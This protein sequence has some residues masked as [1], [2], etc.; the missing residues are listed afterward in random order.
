[1]AIGEKWEKAMTRDEKIKR[2][3][4]RAVQSAFID[5]PDAGNGTTWPQNYKEPA[6]C[7]SIATAVLSALKNEGYQITLESN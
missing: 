3:I 4:E 7:K 5:F 6:E 1:L 2:I